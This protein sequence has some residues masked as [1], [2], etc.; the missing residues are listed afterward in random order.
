MFPTSIS[1]VVSDLIFVVGRVCECQ[2]RGRET[3]L[4]QA[5]HRL[6]TSRKYQPLLSVQQPVMHEPGERH[7]AE[8]TYFTFL[9]WR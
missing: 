7:P 1:F 6:H 8:V 9:H 4:Q 3:H 2:V 5:A